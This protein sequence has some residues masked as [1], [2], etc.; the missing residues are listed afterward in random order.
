MHGPINL[1]KLDRISE[2]GALWFILIA[3]Y[4]MDN[5]INMG[6]MGVTC[7]MHGTDKKSIKNFVGIYERKRLCEHLNVDGR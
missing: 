7:G 1:K 2:W 6:E 4:I 3:T 5:Q